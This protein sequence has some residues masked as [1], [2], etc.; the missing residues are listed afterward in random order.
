MQLLKERIVTFLSIFPWS[1]CRSKIPSDTH[2]FQCSA[3]AYPSGNRPCFCGGYNTAG[4]LL[5]ERLVDEDRSTGNNQRVA[6][7]SLVLQESE[8]EDYPWKGTSSQNSR[9]RQAVTT[10][11]HSPTKGSLIFSSFLNLLNH[12]VPRISE[13]FIDLW[14]A[15][16]SL[17]PETPFSPPTTHLFCPLK[18]PLNLFSLFLPSAVTHIAGSMKMILPTLL[19]TLQLS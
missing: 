19:K 10:L 15:S 16:S 6:G 14:I 13:T 17:T 1:R 3:A 4:L 18:P 11:N 2:P 8:E 9:R 12:F 5:R 7:G